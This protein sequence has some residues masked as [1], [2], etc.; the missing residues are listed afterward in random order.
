MKYTIA[1]NSVIFREM[2]FCYRMHLWMCRECLS[3][4]CGWGEGGVFWEMKLYK[5]KEKWANQSSY[6]KERLD[7]S[8]LL[9]MNVGCNSCNL[10]TVTAKNFFCL[11]LFQSLKMLMQSGLSETVTRSSLGAEFLEVTFWQIVIEVS[12]P[13]VSPLLSPALLWQGQPAKSLLGEC[14]HLRWKVPL[15]DTCSF[16]PHIS[17]WR[18]AALHLASFNLGRGDSSTIKPPPPGWRVF[19]SLSFRKHRKGSKTSFLPCWSHC[20][21]GRVRGKLSPFLF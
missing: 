18:R 4:R 11:F 12:E 10:H 21:L 5:L 1:N 20:S 15:G 7:I 19:H 13:S 9:L 3:G 14:P 8:L 16:T 17:L 6:S 2:I